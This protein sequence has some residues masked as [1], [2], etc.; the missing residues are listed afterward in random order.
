MSTTVSIITLSDTLPADFTFETADA[1]LVAMI[2][3]DPQMRRGFTLAAAPYADAAMADVP[4][5][6][7]VEDEDHGGR[8][9][10]R[11]IQCG[12]VWEAFTADAS[13]L[14][15]QFPAAEVAAA[16]IMWSVER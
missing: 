1:D 16:Y 3:A 4:R 2:V 11:V 15:G 9:V 10:G 14:F 5:Y 13:H 8:T 6:A 7:V 12:R